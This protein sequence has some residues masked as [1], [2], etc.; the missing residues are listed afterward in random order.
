MKV[1]GIS[2]GR[3]LGNSE[4]LLRE[5]LAGAKASD[6]DV[7]LVRL[8]EFEINPCEG[9]SG[10]EQ[11]PHGIID[12]IRH[13]DD[14]PVLMEKIYE[15]DAVIM[16]SPIYTWTPNGL[17]RVLGDRI[18][19]YHDVE[20]LRLKGYE[21][22][23]SPIDQRVFKRRVGAYI[24][25]GGSNDRRYSS[26]ALPMMNQVM[27]PLALSIVDQMEVH[28]AYMPG[29][30]LD[31]DADLKRAF[32]LGENVVRE[33]QKDVPQW[34]AQTEQLCP[35]CHNALFAMYPGEKK[36]YCGN[37]AIVGD[38]VEGEN[39]MTT[40]TFTPEARTKS[41]FRLSK[42]GEHAQF[43]VG[44]QSDEVKQA[45]REMEKGELEREILKYRSY[46]P[47]LIKPGNGSVQTRSGMEQN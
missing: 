20:M 33:F 25:V 3:R 44:G 28:G 17:M 2:S 29:Q 5:A 40:V 47:T 22:E 38:L 15:A 12:C 6:A 21:R 39:G 19:P 32:C 42:M 45:R 8:N 27:Y 16:A 26:M 43:I 4:I 11:K 46:A 13:K 41:R 9:C 30:C 36:V 23:D 1:L 10:C 35:E 34:C 37:C 18:G 14:F 31:N 24:T 7:E